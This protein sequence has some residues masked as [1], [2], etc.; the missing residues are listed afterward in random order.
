VTNS[1][2][3]TGSRSEV[4]SRAN[5]AAAFLSISALDGTRDSRDA[6]GAARPAPASSGR[7]GGDRH[8]DRPA[9]PSCGSPEPRAQTGASSSGV[10]PFRTKSMMRCR[11]FGGTVD[12][13]S[14]SWTVPSPNHGAS[15]KRG[16]LH[17]LRDPLLRSGRRIRH[18]R[19]WRPPRGRGPPGFRPRAH[20][21]W[22]TAIT[23]WGLV[24]LLTISPAC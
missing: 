22:R 12:G 13:S 4:V 19:V 20:A 14:A 1:N 10:R 2:H 3:W 11:N 5:H 8:R 21:H 15:T 7:P 24:L 9:A 17:L 6:D 23:A 16:Q 18:A